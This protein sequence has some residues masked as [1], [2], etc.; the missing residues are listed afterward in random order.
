MADLRGEP[1]HFAEIDAQMIV[2]ESTQ[3]R[4]TPVVPRFVVDK[5]G[6]AGVIGEVEAKPLFNSAY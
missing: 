2:V 5:H 4:G 6:V 1:S 3:D